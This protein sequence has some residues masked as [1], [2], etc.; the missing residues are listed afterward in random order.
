MRE[1]MANLFW[2]RR[3]QKSGKS[4]KWGFAT[5]KNMEN[6][7]WGMRRPGCASQGFAQ[8]VATKD[9]K[10]AKKGGAAPRCDMEGGR[11]TKKPSAEEADGEGGEGY[12]TFG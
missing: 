3:E 11:G 4:E 7:F 1:G 12:L 9:A 2:A 5:G 6:G 10:G 8:G